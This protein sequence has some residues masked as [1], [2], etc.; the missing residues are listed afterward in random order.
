[1]AN[2]SK[3]AELEEQCKHDSAMEKLATEADRASVKYKQ[4]E[5][6]FDS[7]WVRY[8]KGSSVASKEFG[9]FVELIDNGCEEG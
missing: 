2:P 4:V 7:S 3:K 5:Y 6:I 1:M 9:I 8:L